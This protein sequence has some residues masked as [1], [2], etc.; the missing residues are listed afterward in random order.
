MTKYEKEIYHI[1]TASMEHLTA[2]QIYTALKRKYPKVVIATVYNNLNKLWKA[3]MVHKVTVEN[4]PDRYD[5][6]VKHDH[7]VC[8]KCGKLADISFEDLTASLRR[9]MGGDFLYYDLKVFYLCPEC[10]HQ[11]KS[12]E[13]ISKQQ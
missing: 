12:Q 6:T 11:E 10:R 13:D 7:L 2:E 1:I 3:G 8:S 5:R 9:Q 4:M